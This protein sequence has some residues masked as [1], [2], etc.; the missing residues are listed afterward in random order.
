MEVLRARS[1]KTSQ[2]TKYNWLDA[3]P[4]QTPSKASQLTLTNTVT[5]PATSGAGALTGKRLTGLPS[6]YLSKLWSNTHRPTLLLHLYYGP[7][8]LAFIDY[9][10]ILYPPRFTDPNWEFQ[11]IKVGRACGN[12]SGLIKLLLP[13]FRLYRQTEKNLFGVV[14]QFLAGGL[15]I[16]ADDL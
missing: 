7:S 16:S 3:H 4:S 6:V 1:L 12:T 15:F 8:R 13:P 5:R 9:I 14:I 11:T 10:Y 2:W